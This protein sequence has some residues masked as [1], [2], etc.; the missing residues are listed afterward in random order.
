MENQSNNE[1][2]NI[3]VINIEDNG[4]TKLRMSGEQLFHTCNLGGVQF[5]I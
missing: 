5:K 4:F 3:V 1:Q 2:P